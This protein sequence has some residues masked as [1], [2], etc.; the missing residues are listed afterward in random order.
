MKQLNSDRPNKMEYLLLIPLYTVANMMA[1]IFMQK[2]MGI[3]DVT[4]FGAVLLA[5]TTQIWYKV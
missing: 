3:D 1:V 2:V 4:S 5:L